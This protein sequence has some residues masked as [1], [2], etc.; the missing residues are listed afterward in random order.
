MAI[1]F[2][3]HGGW[4]K[5]RMGPVHHRPLDENEAIEEALA[6]GEP[7]GRLNPAG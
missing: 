3:L 5:A 1:A 2:Y 6:E 4:K 7:G